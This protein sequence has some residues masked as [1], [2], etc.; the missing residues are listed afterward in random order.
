M[1][2]IYTNAQGKQVYDY[3][4][5]TYD[6]QTGAVLGAAPA[7]PA[8]SLMPTMQNPPASTTA[9]AGSFPSTPLQPGATGAAVKQLQDYLVSQGLMTE[10]Q[11]AT[12]YGTY[13]PQTTAA[14]KALQSRA[15]VDNSTGPGYFGPKTI[16]AL[17]GGAGSQGGA[18]GGGNSTGGAITI[19]PTGD[20]NLDKVLG[21]VKDLGNGIISSG[22]SIPTTLQITPDIVSRFLDFAHKNIDPYYQQLLTG[23]IA[24]VNA[25]LGNLAAQYEA[26]KGQTLQDFGTALAT[27]QNTAGGAGTAFSGQRALNETNMAATTNR[28]LGSLGSSTAY[29]IGSALRSGAADVGAANA[30]SFNLPTLATGGVSLTGGSRGSTTAGNNLDF[31]YNPS[32]YT[33]GNIPSAQG[34]AAKQLQ[35][36]YLGQYGT[37]AGAQSNSGR[38]VGDLFG[39]MGLK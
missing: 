32:I 27:E 34:T 20:P 10:A 25:N 22:Y 35:Q 38:S 21:A 30:G 18:S 14:V 28:A 23:R 26:T 37:L 29:N 19:T 11:K 1:S 36:T 8:A 16:A 15:G 17:K 3:N 33:V 12:G 24:D 39:M 9:A 7:T 31:G 2:T 5:Q 6:A 4:G 13:G